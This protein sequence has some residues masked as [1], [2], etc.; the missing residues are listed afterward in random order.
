MNRADYKLRRT[1]DREKV[2]L[3]NLGAKLLIDNTKN[4]EDQKK[5]FPLVL[6]ARGK[7]GLAA[8]YFWC[9]SLPF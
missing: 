1:D 9:G 6:G 8:I 7:T 3:F 2:L 4:S 5:T